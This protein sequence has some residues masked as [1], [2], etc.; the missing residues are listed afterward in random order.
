VLFARAML[1][2]IANVM[3]VP[4]SFGHLSYGSLCP[5]SRYFID[6]I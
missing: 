6:T 2:S 3:I 5:G 1:L 4:F